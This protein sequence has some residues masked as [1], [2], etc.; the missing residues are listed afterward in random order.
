MPVGDDLE[1]DPRG[2]QRLARQPRGQQALGGVGQRVKPSRFGRSSTPVPPSASSTARLAAQPVPRV[3]REPNSRPAIVSSNQPART[4]IS[5]RSRA[6]ST[7]GICQD[8]LG[9]TVESARPRDAP[10][11][12]AE[13]AQQRCNG[14]VLVHLHTLVVDGDD[15]RATI[16]MNCSSFIAASPMNAVGISQDPIVAWQALKAVVCGITSQ[17]RGVAQHH[18]AIAADASARS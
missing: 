4:A 3:N 16:D 8:D 1:S 9:S 7:S 11:G 17:L 18:G 12:V 14:G 15:H 6:P 5:T 10:V 2:A 13:R